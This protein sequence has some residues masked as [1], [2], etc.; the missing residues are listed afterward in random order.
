M[1]NNLSQEDLSGLSYSK[2]EF[3]D[4]TLDDASLETR[5]P[6]DN[7]RHS[8][9]PQLSAGTLDLIPPKLIASILESLDLPTLTTFRRVSRRAMALV[10]TLHEYR[11]VAEHCP[12]ILRAILSIRAN[13]FDCRTLYRTLCTTEC[14][15][16]DQVGNY[17]YL[18]TC[19]RVCYLCF[20]ENLDYL[21]IFLAQA[22]R[23]TGLSRE[24]VVLRFPNIR[25][26]PGIYFSACIVFRCYVT[27]FDW[28]CLFESLGASELVPDAEIQH[29]PARG[30]FRRFMSII[31]A[32][33]IGT[34]DQPVDWGVFCESCR[35]RE[36][37]SLNYEFRTKYTRDGFLDHVEWH[38]ESGTLF[39]N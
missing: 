38:R 13:S 1:S 9:E 20:M 35:V 7:G 8:T 30:N 16:C 31:T 32:P 33:V 27:L 4:Y 25:A 19:K 12:D 39:L 15:T 14:A 23:L 11:M 21:P 29:D 36:T 2:Q 18:I 6:L 28:P 22:A 17:L 5:C 3:V 37:P 26:L 10:D 24:K 34:L